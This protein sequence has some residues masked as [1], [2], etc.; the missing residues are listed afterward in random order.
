MNKHLKLFLQGTLLLTPFAITVYII[1]S[2][3]NFIIRTFAGLGI[4][5]SPWLN[6][7][8]GFFSLLGLIYVA[9]ILAQSFIFNKFF[10]NI[11][12]H[13]EKL[14]VIRHIY[15]PVKDFI[16]AFA[17]N[18]K[19]FTKPVLVTTNIQSNI[20]EMGFITQ[21]DLS[22]FSIKDKFAV[23]LPYSYAF[24]GRVIIVPKEQ[25]QEMDIAGS[26]AM[27]FIVSGGVSDIEKPETGK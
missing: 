3:L 23:Y 18:N 25:V 1:Y 21:D 11:E 7:V 22:E 9:G 16:N 19:R 12:E 20:Q 8:V 24:S 13:V 4:F 27:K 15:S 14:P 26:D 5:D 10:D 2:L 6:F 17:G